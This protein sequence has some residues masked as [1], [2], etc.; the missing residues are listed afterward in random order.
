MADTKQPAAPGNQPGAGDT[1]R[2]RAA[3]EAG[4]AMRS[5]ADAA[6]DTGRAAAK[7][8]ERAGQR[9][10]DAMRE[11]A[12]ATADTMRHAGA[13]AER[14][15]AAV[16]ETARKGM[17]AAA[18]R[19]S[20]LVQGAAQE[21]EKTGR[22]LA[23]MVEEAAAGM[24]SLLGPPGV[25]ASNFQEAQHAMSKLVQ[26]VM[27]TN[28]RFADELL[29]RTGP[30]AVVDLQRRFVRE[31]FDALAQGGTLLLRAARQAAEE[32]L[33]PLERK[34]Q[35]RGGDAGF[36][37]NGGRQQQQGGGHGKVA[38]VM[39]KDV[40]LASPEDTVQQAAR[41]MSEQDTGV[42]PVGENDRL[43][44]LVTDRDLAVRAVAA[45]KDPSKTKL[46]EV[47][48][49]EPRYVFEDEPVEQAAASMAEQQVQRLPVLNRD[50][51]L[52]GVVSV[53]DLAREAGGEAAGRA[54][55]GISRP[56]GRHNQNGPASA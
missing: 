7:A 27:E 51:R 15:G 32:S 22:G 10:V 33:R 19:Q 6:Q 35:E 16:A 34:M 25:N 4:G 9:G 31:Y 3:N 50:K 30:S 21:V 2:G 13:A 55:A 23:G 56:G 53:G 52:V 17:Q 12:E 40:K 28:M 5:G 18:E 26:G 8:A 45:G 54:L 11:G 1:V 39:S 49:G 14:G 42:L 43:V 48:S 47:M 44:G 36:A 20:R 38:D 24:R 37:E 46:R 41:V 29:R